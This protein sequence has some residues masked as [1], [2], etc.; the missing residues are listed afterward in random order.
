MLN[1]EVTPLLLKGFKGPFIR[2][3]GYTLNVYLLTIVAVL[4]RLSD[5]LHGLK[6]TPG[7]GC[8]RTNCSS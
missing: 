8:R 2:K 6:G 5:R 4:S 3:L 7:L 1:Y